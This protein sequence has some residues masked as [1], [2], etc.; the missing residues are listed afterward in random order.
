MNPAA[1]LKRLSPL[2]SLLPSLLLGVALIT[3]GCTPPQDGA[4]TGDGR[5]PVTLTWDR[6]MPEDYAF[7]DPLAGIDVSGYADDD[8]EAL[9]LLE[10][11]RAAW[12]DT[13]VVEALDGER[14]RIGGFVVPLEGDGERVT[15]F[16]LVPYEGA[17][18]H[19]PP[20]PPNQVIHVQMQAP[21]A[22]LRLFDAVW[23]TGTLQARRV[24]SDLADAG[25]SMRPERIEAF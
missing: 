1:T 19:V 10:K 5:E 24:P 2:R 14:V 23:L 3:P 11:L 8:P 4:S 15:E 17:C 21:G 13:P 9:A 20:P 6:L 7:E 18:I 25:Y 22:R 12:A 16:L